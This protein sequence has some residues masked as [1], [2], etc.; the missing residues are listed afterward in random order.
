MTADAHLSPTCVP[1]G[2]ATPDWTSV[3]E[4]LIGIQQHV[5]LDASGN[6]FVSRKGTTTDS[7]QEQ[8]GI[9]KLDS[10]GGLKWGRGYDA[11]GFPDPPTDPST[12][13]PPRIAATPSGGV[14]MVTEVRSPIE[15]VTGGFGGCS[16]AAPCALVAAW[17]ADG[18]PLFGVVPKV[19]SAAMNAT[20]SL[21]DVAVDGTGD[22]WIVG[23]R[24]GT[25]DLGGAALLN[26]DVSSAFVAE[27]NPQ[28]H[29]VWA[30]SLPG[31]DTVAMLPA[32]GAL[33]AGATIP[34]G[35]YLATINPTGKILNDKTF[36][37]GSVVIA[38]SADANGGSVIAIDA[39]QSGS[40]YTF[41]GASIWHGVVK[42]DANFNMIWQIPVNGRLSG[43]TGFPRKP[44]V[45]SA[46][47]VAFVFESA[48]VAGPLP[49]NGSF[50]TI[51]DESGSKS[52]VERF[53]TASLDDVTFGGPTA[54]II[55]GATRPA[56]DL[57]AGQ[58]S[59]P[60]ETGFAARLATP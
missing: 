18:Q 31:A 45:N 3:S 60:R 33:V 47:R 46:G 41:G 37:G 13:R 53:A 16:S 10:L 44:S 22:I 27:L 11:P 19:S 52:F 12:I 2:C 20:Y 23:R 57:G 24:S 36:S 39:A 7:C 5:V 42:L 59:A 6:T 9:E 14:V 4:A 25:L 29:G 8:I 32:G 21:G 50:V 54:L 17:D 43:S 15:F 40:A 56:A 34:D 28:G 35:A 55:A 38:A 49:P 58:L 26:D 1:A 51:V 48:D 30:T